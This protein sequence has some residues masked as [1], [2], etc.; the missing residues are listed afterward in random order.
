MISTTRKKPRAKR[1]FI[2]YNKPETQRRDKV[3]IS[4][5]HDNK[6]HMVDNVVCSLPTEG[7]VNKRQPYFV[8]QGY[9]HDVKIKKG[10]AYIT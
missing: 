8:M 5:H 2:H 10:I 9:C 4:V 3:T 7:K 1:F 6:C